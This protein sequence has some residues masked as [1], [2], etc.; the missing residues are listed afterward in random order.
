MS[1]ISKHKITS[2]S[3]VCVSPNSGPSPQFSKEQHEEVISLHSTTA[4]AFGIND[5]P[6]TKLQSVHLSSFCESIMAGADP[7]E[8]APRRRRH[9]SESRRSH[10][11]YVTVCYRI[12]KALRLLGTDS[13]S[14]ALLCTDRLLTALSPELKPT[15]CF[16][17]M[18][19][20]MRR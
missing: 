1:K 17:S 7:E 14:A 5:I 6:A 19:I 20:L 9:L 4:P 3:N 11:Q 2:Q 10:V 15:S 13:S 16:L 8:A 18:C 12:Y